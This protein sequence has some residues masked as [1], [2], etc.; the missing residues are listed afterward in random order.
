MVGTRKDPIT[1]PKNKNFYLYTL[2]AMIS[3]H[4]FV[5]NWSRKAFSICMLSNLAYLG[6]LFAYAMKEVG[7]W[8]IAAWRVFVFFGISFGAFAFLEVIEYIEH[9]GLIL[10]LIHI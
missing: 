7:D 4:T 5:Y 10:S 6:I 3:A 2:Q 1:S 9:Y 8:Q